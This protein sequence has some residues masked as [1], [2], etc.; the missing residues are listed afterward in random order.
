MKSAVVTSV[1]LAVVTSLC[2]WV[3]WRSS[4]AVQVQDMQHPLMT[5]S[6]APVQPDQVASLRVVRWDSHEKAPKVFE[7]A[8]R[9]N[10]WIIPSHFDYPADKG[11]KVGETA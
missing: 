7:V 9:N 8:R 11:A 5:A 3:P 4:T 10:S 2:A 6:G 1:V